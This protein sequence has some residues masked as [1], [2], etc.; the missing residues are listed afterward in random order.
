MRV[1]SHGRT[2]YVEDP[3]ERADVKC[4][5]NAAH[6]AEESKRSHLER[7]MPSNENKLDDM[8]SMSVYA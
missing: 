8:A 1:I 2:E 4:K 5:H 7:G 3:N 6:H